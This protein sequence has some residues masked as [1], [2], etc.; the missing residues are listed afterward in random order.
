M[1]KIVCA[2]LAAV[3]CPLAASAGEISYTYLEGGVA[4]VQQDA[5]PGFSDPRFDGAYLR[6]SVE[7]G[8]GFYAF[9]E[10]AR[11]E[12]RNDFGFDVDLKRSQVGAGYAHGLNDRVDL[13]AEL[14]YLGESL[15][16]F[17]DDAG[18]ASL[19]LRSQLGSRMEGWAKA[20]YT[21]GDSFNG[22]VSAT[23]GALYRF[24][25]TWGLTGEAELNEHVDRV[26]LGIR[27]NF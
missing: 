8:G 13:T 9:G 7:L 21:D 15:D 22:D 12:L 19:G 17:D 26:T 23:V 2:A 10:H 14:G 4:R 18:R 5:P 20:N 24:T 25:P 27:A 1:K 6:G 3:L 16:W 11:T